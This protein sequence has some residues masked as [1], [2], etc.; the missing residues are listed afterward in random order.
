MVDALAPTVEGLILGLLPWLVVAPETRSRS[1]E[2]SNAVRRPR[3]PSLSSFWQDRAPF[4]KF[5]QLHYAEF[6]PDLT[7]RPKFVESFAVAADVPPA[8]YSISIFGIQVW[9]KGKWLTLREFDSID[10]MTGF[11]IPEHSLYFQML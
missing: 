7:A 11:P 1:L 5:L 8:V 9:T 2:R 3:S 6:S 4:Y 10:L